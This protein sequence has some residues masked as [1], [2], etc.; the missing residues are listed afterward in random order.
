ME[1]ED[2]YK[3]YKIGISFTIDVPSGPL[4]SKL[5]TLIL[6]V[7]ELRNIIEYNFK[8]DIDVKMFNANLD[9]II[10]TCKNMKFMEV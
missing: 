7:S 8:S 2:K 4:Q 3:T 9:S 10:N 1:A 6:D 5:N